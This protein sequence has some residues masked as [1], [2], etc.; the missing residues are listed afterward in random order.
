MTLQDN[1]TF[2]SYLPQEVLAAPKTPPNFIVTS[3]REFQ[4]QPFYVDW[5]SAGGRIKAPPSKIRWL[6]VAQSDT[7]LGW[8]ETPQVPIRVVVYIYP[9]VNATGIPR[10]DL[11]SEYRC[12]QGNSPQGF[13]VY[14]KASHSGKDAILLN[15]RHRLDADAC[16]VVVNVSWIVP[17]P[18][19]ELSGNPDNNEVSASWGW[20]RCS[21]L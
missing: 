5:S 4:L 16:Y 18:Q 3:D 7:L 20:H 1:A 8:L 10:E 13:C 6:A 19:V 12:I 17:H 11:G 14:H 21:H 2:T 15:L 9:Q